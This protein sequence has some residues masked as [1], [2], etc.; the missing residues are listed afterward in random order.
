VRGRSLETVKPGHVHRTFIRD[1]FQALATKA[2][3]TWSPPPAIV[4]RREM[5]VTVR[6]TVRVHFS[7]VGCGLR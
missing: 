5:H 4:G 2:Y 1:A 3:R 7:T 6:V